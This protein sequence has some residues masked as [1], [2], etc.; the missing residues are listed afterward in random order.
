MSSSPPSPPWRFNNLLFHSKIKNRQSS[1]VNRQSSVVSRQSSIVS[2][3]SS[4]VSRQS[5]FSPLRALAGVSV[6]LRGRCFGVSAIESRKRQC[7]A[8][9]SFSLPPKHRAAGNRTTETP[10]P[11]FLRSLAGVAVPLRGQCFS[12]SVRAERKQQ[13]VATAPFSLPPKHRNTETPKHRLPSSS[14][15]SASSASPRFNNLPFQNQQSTINNRQSSINLLFPPRPPRRPRFNHLPL[16]LSF[17]ISN[18]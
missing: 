5:I 2:R 11:L 4:V 9:D 17:L 15:S 6:P 1:I 8:T 7:A 18:S 13:C 3:Q 12:S 14:A 10:S 16:P